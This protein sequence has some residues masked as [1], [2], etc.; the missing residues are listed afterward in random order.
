MASSSS[1]NA[2]AVFWKTKFPLRTLKLK[3]QLLENNRD[4]LSIEDNLVGNNSLWKSYRKRS[5]S[6]SPPRIR[7]KVTIEYTERDATTSKHKINT[8]S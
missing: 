8:L 1:A 2:F 3:S 6:P 5:R 4:I 7:D